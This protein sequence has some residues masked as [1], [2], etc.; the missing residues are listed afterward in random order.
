MQWFLE[1]WMLLLVGGGL[2]AMKLFPHG[3]K[4]RDHV[5]HPGCANRV[6]A[7]KAEATISAKVGA[8]G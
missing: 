8:H 6:E 5:S 7:L 3:R 1:N 4:D 2:V